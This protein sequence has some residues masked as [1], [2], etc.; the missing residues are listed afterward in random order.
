MK[1][2]FYHLRKGVVP[3]FIVYNT[4]RI[5]GGWPPSEDA[6]SFIYYKE[7][8]CVSPF[9]EESSVSPSKEGSSPPPSKEASSI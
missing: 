7:E 5:L 9:K 2:V 3:F 4:T 8:S 1:V 6:S